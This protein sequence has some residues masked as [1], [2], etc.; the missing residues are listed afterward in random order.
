MSSKEKVRDFLSETA[1]EITTS[2][3][4]SVD[5]IYEGLTHLFKCIDKADFYAGCLIGKYANPWKPKKGEKLTEEMKAQSYEYIKRNEPETAYFLKLL[6][7]QYV[8]DL[9]GFEVDYIKRIEKQLKP[10]IKFCECELLSAYDRDRLLL[11]RECKQRK[12]K[13]FTIKKYLYSFDKKVKKQFKLSREKFAFLAY[14]LEFDKDSQT[15]LDRWER[16]VWSK[17][18]ERLKAI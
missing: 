13:K 9:A 18:I 14:F 5:G 16:L 1:S 11:I 17:E 8:F 3:C 12:M 2:N 15:K 7:K 6:D 4:V 10:L